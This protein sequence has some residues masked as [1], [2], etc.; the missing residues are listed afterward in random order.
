MDESD[1]PAAVRRNLMKELG[2]EGT[3]LFASD[4]PE[5]SINEDYMDDKFEV[6][7]QGWGSDKKG[8]L[9]P[10]TGKLASVKRTPSMKD[11]W[12][13][14]GYLNFLEAQFQVQEEEIDKAYNNSQEYGLNMFKDREIFE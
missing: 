5:F 13:A 12:E 10:E 6:F 3:L 11:Y 7:Q 8:T 9:D 14:A 2:E 4:G 1:D